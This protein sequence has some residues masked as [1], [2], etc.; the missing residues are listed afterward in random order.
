MS[1][2]TKDTTGDDDARLVQ[3]IRER[4]DADVDSLDAAAL[5]HLEQARR[6]AVAAAGRPGRPR[7]WTARPGG[8][9]PSDWLVPAGAFASVVAAA[10]ALSILVED[11]GNGLAREVEDLEMLTAG[12]EIELYE[13]LEFYQW[14]QDRESTG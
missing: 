4:L 12:E 5:A 3:R 2:S 8:R 13:N 11:P 14:L 6:H 10:V 1:R 7:L 9:A